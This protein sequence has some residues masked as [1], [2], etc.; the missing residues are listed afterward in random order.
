MIMAGNDFKVDAIGSNRTNSIQEQIAKFR[1]LLPNVAHNN[2][3]ESVFTGYFTPQSSQ[4]TASAN[5]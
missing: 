1:K 5:N 3:K 4:N 2:I